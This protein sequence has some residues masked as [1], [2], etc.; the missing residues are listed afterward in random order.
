MISLPH[1][2]IHLWLADYEELER[3]DL[4]AHRALL[5]E[6]ERRQERRFH[7]ARDRRRYLA[8]RVLVRTVLSRYLH[9]RPDEWIFS[10][11]PNGRPQIA[12]PGFADA[13]L[14]FNLSHTHSLIAL[15][16]AADR[17]IGIDVEN[18]Q[19][20]PAPI[21]VA[22]RVFTPA[23]ADALARLPA[24]ARQRRFFEHWT[25][26]EA[27]SKARGMGL[28]IPLNR[29]GFHFPDE[30][31]VAIAMAPELGDS[32]ARWQ[33]WQ[34]EPAPRYLIAV[35]AERAANRP[36]RLVLRQCDAIASA[37]ILPAA[38]TRTSDCAATGT[39]TPPA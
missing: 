13:G 21:D 11:S 24:P 9:G 8:T 14:R 37:R 10:K 30:T 34:L 36:A 6:E 20:R 29:F 22:A 5:N 38:V 26:K 32:P 31:G 17:L 4:R 33:F 23:E 39:A 35:C 19:D 27:Y 16:I 28:S 18:I 2:D 12:N 3:A 15:A 25:F 1:D 7:F